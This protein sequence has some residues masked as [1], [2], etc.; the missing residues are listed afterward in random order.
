MAITNNSIAY[1]G[2]TT[3]KYSPIK[4]AHHFK[5]VKKKVPFLWGD[6]V[7]V[8]NTNSSKSRISAKGHILDVPTKDLTDKPIFCLWQIDCGQGDASLMRFPNGRVMMIDG[9]P[10][11]LMSNS[12]AMAPAFLRWM[13][14][15]DQSWRDEFLNQE[16]PFVIDGLVCSHPDYDHFGGFLDMI[17]DIKQGTFKIGQVYH[18][19]LGRFDGDIS[20]F[21]NNKGM[22]ELGPVKGTVSPELYLT[23]LL[24]GFS[25]VRKYSR[26]TTNRKWKLKGT[27]GKLLKELEKMDGS[28]VDHMQRIHAGMGKLPD[29]D[30]GADC[31]VKVLGP[32]EENYRGQPALRYIDGMTKSKMAKPSLT[33]NGISIVQRIDIGK[34]RILMTGDLNFRSQALLLNNI[35]A[36]EFKCHI[37]KACHHGSED[38][39]TTFL[40]AMSP[41]AT[42]FS[43]GDNE[44]HAHPRAKVLGMAGAFTQPLTSGVSEFLGLSEPK[45]KAP[46]IYS[47]EL[48]RSVTL[49]EPDKLT[50]DDRTI[51]GAILSSKGAGGRKGPKMSMNDW[52]LADNLIYGLINVRTDGERVVIGMLK[53]GEDAGFQI[54]SFK[55]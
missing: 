1:I 16:S 36:T 28:G 53:E 27:Y 30:A 21:S 7:W 6:S 3:K 51:R 39:S 20:E 34:V 33:R 50:K 31:A 19:G 47:T 38:I 5:T 10:G 40:R 13:R 12:P 22:S 42:L 25:D 48:S 49:F 45:Y 29:F 44:T 9:G 55:V 46:L 18:G 54:E 11:P 41:L 26:R 8:I 37:G 4:A 43:S 35:P 17:N 14:F 32:I 15:V 24:D 2:V 52:L 23:T